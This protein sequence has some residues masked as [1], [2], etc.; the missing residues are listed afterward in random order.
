M[1]LLRLLHSIHVLM[2]WI[3]D[4]M[5]CCAKVNN[6]IQNTVAYIRDNDVVPFLSV[7]AVRRLVRLL[8]DVYNET[9]HIYFWNRWK[10]YNEYALIPDVITKSVLNEIHNMSRGFFCSVDGECKMIMPA[11]RVVWCKHNFGGTF[12]CEAD[13]VAE[14]N[15]FLTSDMISDH[16]PENYEDALDAIF[17]KLSS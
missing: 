16:M 4:H 2:P 11:R 13:K 6:V 15:I 9:E 7:A 12:S 10:I 3:V 14:G 17:E 8:D 1:L 5:D